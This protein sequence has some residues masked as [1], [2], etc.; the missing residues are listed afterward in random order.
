MFSGITSGEVIYEQVH[1]HVTWA[2]VG[3]CNIALPS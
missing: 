1:E 2:C 3:Q